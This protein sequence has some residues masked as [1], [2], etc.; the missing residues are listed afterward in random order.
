MPTALVR[1]SC[2][3]TPLTTRIDEIDQ[4]VGEQ[5]GVHAQVTM[6]GQG[7][8]MALGIDPVPDWIVAPFGMLRRPHTT[9]D[10]IVDRAAGRW[11]RRT[12]GPVTTSP[13]C[14]KMDV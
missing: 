8:R 3:A 1:L 6:I 10:A 4:P 9:C 5:F 14:S 7:G 13:P 11:G 2:F 12:F